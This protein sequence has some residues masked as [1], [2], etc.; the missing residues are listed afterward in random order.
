VVG[1]FLLVILAY[2]LGFQAVSW[3]GGFLAATAGSVVL[4]AVLGLFK[5]K[6]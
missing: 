5:K 2:Q 3:L 1:V 4:L 6:T